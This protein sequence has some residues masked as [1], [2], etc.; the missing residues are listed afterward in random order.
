MDNKDWEEI[1]D[2]VFDKNYVK[3]NPSKFLNALETILKKK[4]YYY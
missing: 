2:N 3:G 4:K 1:V